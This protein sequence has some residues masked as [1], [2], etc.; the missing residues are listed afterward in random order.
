M[1][2]M[3][4]I[5]IQRKAIESLAYVHQ[6]ANTADGK[7]VMDHV[8]RYPWVVLLPS[9]GEMRHPALVLHNYAGA[10]HRNAYTL[11]SGE[12][13]GPLLLGIL[14][15]QLL[16]LAVHSNALTI[17][18]PANYTTGQVVVEGTTSKG[19]A[20]QIP[21]QKPSRLPLNWRQAMFLS[22]T[23]GTVCQAVNPDFLPDT[24]YGYR[25]IVL[26]FPANAEH[27]VRVLDRENPDFVGI[28]LPIREKQGI[29]HLAGMFED[30]FL[31]VPPAPPEP[32]G[33]K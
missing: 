27:P 1:T 12:L 9:I 30:P 19:V 29:S 25:A 7:A 8:L 13:T 33:E 23:P 26:G 22:E 17:E 16:K 6:A 32:A 21:T 14:A 15:P 24:K 4:S 18:V 3:I 28:A 2:T 5:N 11:I 31:W 20:F 10:M